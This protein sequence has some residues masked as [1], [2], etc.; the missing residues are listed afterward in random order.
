MPTPS[1]GPDDRSAASAE[2]HALASGY[3]FTAALRAAAVHGIA[4]HLADGPMTPGELA[5]RSHT[6]GPSLRRVLRLLAMG[7]VFREDDDNAF[8][9]TPL[10]QLLRRDVPGSQRAAILMLTD[11]FMWRS[12]EGL[13]ETVRTGEP[14]FET[15]Y[16]MPFFAY[17]DSAPA[18]QQIFD[19]G[20]ADL[21]V[22]DNE[23]IAAHCACPE[24]GTVVD[25]GG[26]R[27]GLLRAVLSRLPELSGVLYDR[28]RTVADHVLDHKE[29]AGRWRVET[30]DFFT[31]VPPG[32][33][34]YLLKHVLHDWDDEHCLRILRS[35]RAAMAPGGRLL[36]VETV[37][38]PGNEPGTGKVVDVIMLMKLRGKER[39]REEFAALLAR[40]AFRMTGIV[41]TEASASVIEAQAV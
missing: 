25:V 17:L 22:R 15:A 7:G 40:S 39:T 37:L 23:H 10:S 30:G 21:S 6:H 20:M 34:V 1:S 9:L 14:A 41:P 38:P 5:R 26:G 32:G 24:S 33:D 35:I 8:R 18:A 28:E 13:T 16:G 31:A 12:A 27:G 2:L 19:A 11:P 4:D 3:L 29:L 36:V